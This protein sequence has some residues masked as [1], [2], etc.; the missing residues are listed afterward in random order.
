[1][2]TEAERTIILVQAGRHRWHLRVARVSSATCFDGHA[3]I[4]PAAG[5]YNTVVLTA[6]F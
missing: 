2:G 6:I 5:A 4:A 3:D 1:M